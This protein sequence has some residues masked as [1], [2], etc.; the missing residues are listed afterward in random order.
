MLML[1]AVF[2]FILGDTEFEFRQVHH[3]ISFLCTFLQLC[4]HTTY[5]SNLNTFVLVIV[6]YDQQEATIFCLHHHHH[7]H[8]HVHE[9]LGVF[10]VP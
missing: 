1:S 5:T 8:H 3:R 7:H 2:Y 6:N 4:R 10:P 9:G